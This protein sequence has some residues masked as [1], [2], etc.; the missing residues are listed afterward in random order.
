MLVSLTAKKRSP[1][2]MT[3]F[4]T[5][6]L[7]LFAAWALAAAAAVQAQAATPVRTS[8]ASTPIAASEM[9]DRP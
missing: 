6:S 4:E 2:S 9:A 8:R 7:R 3:A 5:H 1:H